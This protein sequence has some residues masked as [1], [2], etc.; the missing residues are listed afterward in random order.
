[1]QYFGLLYVLVSVDF[2]VLTLGLDKE[3]IRP[4]TF[5]D[6]SSHGSLNSVVMALH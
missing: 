4:L 1:M 3:T 6:K 2:Y 5:S